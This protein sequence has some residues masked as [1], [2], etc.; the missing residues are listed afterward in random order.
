MDQVSQINQTIAQIQQKIALFEKSVASSDAGFP[1]RENLAGPAKLVVP[2]DTPLLNRLPT[3]PGSGKA[4]AWKE[5]TSFGADPDSVFYAEGGAPSSRTTVYA[6]RSE[7]YRLLGLDGGVHGFAIAAG[8]NF[9][10]QVATEQRNCILHLKRLEEVALISA[11]GT[12]IAFSGLLTQI[13][14]GNGSTVRVSTGTAGS[15]VLN[16]LDYVLQTVWDKGAD[17]SFFL[18]RSSEAKLVS[19]T[20]TR[21]AGTSPMRVCF[22]TNNQLV[23]GFYVNAYISPLSGKKVELVPEKFLSEGTIICVAENLP[24]PISGQGGEAAYLDVLLDYASSPVPTANDSTLFRIKR[25]YTLVLPGRIFDAK[26]TGF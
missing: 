3:K 8:A 24:N 21:N 22:D 14:T 11:P 1:V 6:D 10:D 18:L 16:D 4:A 20:I 26:I 2:V 12:G 13:V 19:D 7:V 9:S 23:G 15:A 5:I 25:Y 17:I